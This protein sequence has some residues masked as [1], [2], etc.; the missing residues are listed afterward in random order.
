MA[1]I[2][3]NFTHRGVLVCDSQPGR[4][5]VFSSVSGSR[6]TMHGTSW[7]R[8]VGRF[9]STGHDVIDTIKVHR[10]SVR[11]ATINTTAALVAEHG[12]ASMTMSQIAKEAGSGRATLY[13][14]FPDVES[15]L[16]TWHER[17][18]S[19]HLEHL[20]GLGNQAG[21]PVARVTAVLMAYALIQHEHHGT[22]LAS[23]L[24]R[25]E[26]VGRAQRHLSIMIRDLL[27]QGVG[28][29][30]RSLSNWVPR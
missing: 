29:G 24:L 21:D 19:G 10:R 23:L 25:G 17:Q 22:E 2:P 3:N 11:D 18:V 30:D 7:V 8:R 4:L 12:L 13:E 26:H 1:T 27:T 20:A 6:S 9:R 15:I 14:Y 28:T 16:V 5:H